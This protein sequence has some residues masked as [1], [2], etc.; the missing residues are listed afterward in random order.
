MEPVS[1]FTKASW[2][3]SG[4]RDL[5]AVGGPGGTRAGPVGGEPSD[6]GAVGVHRVDVLGAVPADE[7]DLR[8]IRG[9]GRPGVSGLVREPGQPG[10]VRVH[11]VDATL[12]PAPRERDGPFGCDT[13]RAM[14]GASDRQE[15]DHETYGEQQPQR[16]RAHPP[17][18][19]TAP[20]ETE[21]LLQPIRREP[22]PFHLPPGAFPQVIHGLRRPRQSAPAGRLV[23]GGGGYERTAHECPG[24][25]PPP[26]LGGRATPPARTLRAGPPAVM[27]APPRARPE[28]PLAA[29]RRVA[30]PL[31]RV[32]W[33]EPR[34]A[35]DG[36]D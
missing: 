27:P 2:V 12:R 14:G 28:S 25:G 7:G 36:C 22:E 10:A 30:V 20:N 19:P 6:G 3:P 15:P 33:P 8:P 9:P 34:D 23:L 11:R 18:P 13:G 5:R 29:D 35:E 17:V 26:P 16:A 24:D 31:K 21:R 4:D 32:A 1:S